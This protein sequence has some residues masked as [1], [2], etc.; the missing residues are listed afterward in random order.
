MDKFILVTFPE[1]QDFMEH[2]RFEECIFINDDKV[3]DSSYMVPED[4]YNE[5]LNIKITSE[6][7]LKEALNYIH[8]S[9]FEFGEDYD[10]ENLETK[11]ETYISTLNI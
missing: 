11:I 8:M 2:E 5:V 10:S 9:K 1:I 4:L 6:S 3:P 7:L